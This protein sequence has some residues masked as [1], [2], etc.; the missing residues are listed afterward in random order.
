MEKKEDNKEKKRLRLM[1]N[2]Y[3]K[4]QAE[5]LKKAKHARKEITLKYKK[6]IA[7]VKQEFLT[8][9]KNLEKTKVKKIKFEF[10]ERLFNLTNQRDYEIAK[11]YLTERKQRYA[12]MLVDKRI[13]F[14][15]YH[16][17]LKIAKQLYLDNLDKF[18]A[19]QKQVLKQTKDK[20]E[21]EKINLEFEQKITEAKISYKNAEIVLQEQRDQSYEYEIDSGFILKRWFFGVGK[22]YQRMSYPS[23]KKTLRDFFIVIVVAGFIAGLFLLI[24]F[25]FTTF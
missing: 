25:I 3:I 2:D 15:I 21:K 18:K 14:K 7:G 9:K 8:N 19:D 13:A 20:K 17:K 5:K 10:K 11:T 1:E 24:D 22:E 4:K 12:K 6:K 16:E 23:A